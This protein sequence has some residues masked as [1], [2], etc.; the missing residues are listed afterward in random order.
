MAQASLY[1]SADW[2]AIQEDGTKLYPLHQFQQE[3]YYSKHRFTAAIAGTGGGKT[4]LGGVWIA[5]KCAEIIASGRQP[6]GMVIAPTH[7]VLMRATVPALIE[8][9]AGTNL[10]GTF[11]SQMGVYELPGGGKIWCQGADNP[12]GLEGGQFDFVW[13]DEAGQ[14]KLKVWHAITG[15]TGLKQAQILLTTT[16]YGFNWLYLEFYKRAQA[17]DPDYKVVQFNSIANPAYPKEEFERARRELTT[18]RFN[19]RYKGLFLNTEGLVFPGLT[20]CVV[21]RSVE[22]VLSE[23]GRLYG[24]IDYGW[25]DPFC[26]L[27]GLLDE[28]D[29]LWIWYERYMPKR[30][31]EDHAEHLPKF[32]DRK[33]LW[34]ADHTPELTQKLKRGGHRVKKAY[35]SIL[36][37]VDAVNARIK[38]QRLFICEGITTKSAPALVVEGGSY[39]YYQDENEEF[40]GDKPDPKCEDH[41]CDALRYMIAGIDIRR[42]A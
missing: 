27:C 2:G 7:K 32:L 12:G 30:T 33:P 23:S 15:R 1:T 10:E 25:N 19:M 26:A 4:A 31:I 21:D 39:L 3:C 40:L 20:E 22:D 16:P 34:F 24:G 38:T 41:A 28:N 6:L 11:K 37:G 36:P 42:A 29:V 8:T 17:G 13:A 14:M 35:K 18:D 9:F 5:K